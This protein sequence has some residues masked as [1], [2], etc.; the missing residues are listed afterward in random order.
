MWDKPG[1]RVDIAQQGVAAGLLSKHDGQTLISTNRGQFLIID[2]W[3]IDVEA[4][5]YKGEIVKTPVEPERQRKFVI[6][7]TGQWEAGESS[8]F[9]RSVVI[10]SGQILSP[11]GGQRMPDVFKAAWESA[12][13]PYP[14]GMFGAPHVDGGVASGGLV[15]GTTASATDVG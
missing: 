4:S 2:G 15:G 9:V 11:P 3:V 12:N 8:V 5:R 13:R 6:P 10:D 14:S 1:T 7:V